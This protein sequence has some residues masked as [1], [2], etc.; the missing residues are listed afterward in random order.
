MNVAFLMSIRIAATTNIN[1]FKMFVLLF[2]SPI[3]IEPAQCLKIFNYPINLN[4]YGMRTAGPSML[5]TQHF[6]FI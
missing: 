6:N 2:C 5:T 3:M 1:H 4:G